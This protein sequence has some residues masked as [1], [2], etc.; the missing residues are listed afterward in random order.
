LSLYI[1]F[2]SNLFSFIPASIF[3]YTLPS[4]GGVFCC[5]KPVLKKLV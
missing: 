3:F 5:A 4:P 1:L 2:S